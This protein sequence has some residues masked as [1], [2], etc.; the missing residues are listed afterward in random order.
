MSRVY[1]EPKAIEALDARRKDKCQ[2]Q[3]HVCPAVL[4][5]IH[6]P[7]RI[8]ES[9]SLLSSHARGGGDTGIHVNLSLSC[10]SDFL[11]LGVMDHLNSYEA[12]KL[13]AQ[14]SVF[15]CGKHFPGS[16]KFSRAPQG[17]KRSE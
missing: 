10:I 3:S 15:F 16:S 7:D 14:F 13:H 9:E 5:G 2:R 17:M 4:G 6:A 8:M 1:I 12:V 11:N